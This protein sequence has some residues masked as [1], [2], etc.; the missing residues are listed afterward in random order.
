MRSVGTC[1]L[2]RQH[3]L[4]FGPFTYIHED[5]LL[6][7]RGKEAQLSFRLRTTLIHS[8]NLGLA[9]VGRLANADRPTCSLQG[10]YVERE[11]PVIHLN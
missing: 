7:G 3:S 11:A 1:K 9:C 4:T 2:A 10:M 6:Q 5:S 8:T